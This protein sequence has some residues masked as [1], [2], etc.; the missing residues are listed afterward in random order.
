M[1]G[2]SSPSKTVQPVVQWDIHSWKPEPDVHPLPSILLLVLVL[3]PHLRLMG[4]L[5]LSNNLS[6]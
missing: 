5:R 2:L 6:S 4:L 1:L 3:F